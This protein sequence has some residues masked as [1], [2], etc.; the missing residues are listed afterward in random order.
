MHTLVLPST[1][2]TTTRVLLLE[3][4]T[5]T[6]TSTSTTVLLSLPQ[7]VM[8]PFTGPETGGD[9][10][11]PLRSGGDG[12]EQVIADRTQRRRE[13]AVRRIVFDVTRLPTWSSSGASGGNDG[14]KDNTNDGD[15]GVPGATISLA[16]GD[17]N[18][19]GAISGS[20]NFTNLPDDA[21]LA[22]AVA[23]SIE[24]GIDRELHNELVRQ[25]R[26]SAGIISKI[27][28]DHSDAFLGS[29]GRVVALGGPCGELRGK[30]E[31][32]IYFCFVM[33]IWL[34]FFVLLA[35]GL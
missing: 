6:T 30:V 35:L 14:I 13:D 12:K 4:T 33:I 5:T 3:S 16:T 28:H 23:A 34:N 8:A 15:S 32:V 24:R 21:L 10:T 31:E 22:S 17:T 7:I 11:R 18:S 27:C 29:V 26:E 20:A 2:S 9:T 19:T 1:T 25:A